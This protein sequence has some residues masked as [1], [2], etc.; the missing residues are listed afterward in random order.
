MD[1]RVQQPNSLLQAHGVR[2][3]RKEN[4]ITA[5]MGLPKDEP[6]IVV[7]QRMLA[8]D[9]QWQPA[10][11]TLISRGWLVVSEIDDYPADTGIKTNA[12]KW[13]KS[14]GWRGYGCCHGVQTSTEELAKKLREYNPEV[15]IFENQ[16]YR[17]PKFERREDDN[18][19]IF[20]GALNRKDDWKSL[21][22]GFNRVVKKHAKAQF[23]VVRDREFFDALETQNKKLVG[24]A[25][26]EKYMSL[27]AG[28][29]IALLPLKDTVFKRCKSD[30]KFAEAGGAGVA[31]IASPTAY[32]ASIKDGETGLIARSVA[33][34]ETHLDKLITDRDLCRSIQRNAQSYVIRER[35]LANHIHKRIDWY[36]S[37]WD[38]RE[39][40]TRALVKRF[41][42]LAP[43][44]SK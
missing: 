40:L 8:T 6:K 16:L 1:V 31:V 35:M 21:M 5:P 27:M 2:L 30:I 12:S 29:D 11:K 33:D 15:S 13:A 43:Q 10:M 37:L 22:P 26:Y 32:E 39:E 3:L 4:A 34:W 38:R 41:P 18:I 23:I 42:E 36:R 20:F 7:V 28:S 44:R 17:L 9:G 24:D 19:R 25:D 14:M